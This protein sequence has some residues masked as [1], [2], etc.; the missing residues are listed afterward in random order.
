MSQTYYENTMTLSSVAFGAPKIAQ[1][2]KTI[3]PALIL[4][5]LNPEPM[6][7]YFVQLVVMD[8][9]GHF[10]N[11]FNGQQDFAMN[12]VMIKEAVESPD[13]ATDDT[14][15]YAV[16][17]NI[18]MEVPGE[19]VY[20]ITAML[21]RKMP[22]GGSECVDTTGLHFEIKCN[23]MSQPE[24]TLGKLSSKLVLVARTDSRRLWVHDS[25]NGWNLKSH[26]R[27]DQMR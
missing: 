19:S 5:V 27:R 1:K 11:L 20:K 23:L 16:F 2:G 13:P 10:Y 26:N 24:V 6:V 8:S 18:A 25:S 9:A 15:L 21:M 3:D 12:S 4:T 7:H 22:D 17:Q 14:N